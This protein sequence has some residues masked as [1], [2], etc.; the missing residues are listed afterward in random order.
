LP[1][2]FHRPTF[3]SLVH[4]FYTHRPL[5]PLKFDQSNSVPFIP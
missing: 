2:S 5:L 3:F 1:T 4:Y